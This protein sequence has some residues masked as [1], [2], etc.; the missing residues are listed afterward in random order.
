MLNQMHLILKQFSILLFWFQHLIY[1][2]IKK[3][4]FLL[5]FK[6]ILIDI[7]LLSILILI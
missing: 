1:Q 7:L 4:N 5:I 3:A 6:Y 2:Q